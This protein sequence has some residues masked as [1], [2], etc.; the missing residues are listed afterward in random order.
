MAICI[1]QDKS[2]LW[3][4][5]YLP[6]LLVDQFNLIEAYINRA[7]FILD[8]ENIQ[9]KR[10]VVDEFVQYFFPDFHKAL[11]AICTSSTS[12]DL[13]PLCP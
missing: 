3:T 7:C 12:G 4:E 6:E 9:Y 11:T 10:T 1:S 8:S 13:K 2:V 5:K